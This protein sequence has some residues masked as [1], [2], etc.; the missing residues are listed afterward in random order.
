MQKPNDP[1][2][3]TK[4]SRLNDLSQDECT[5]KPLPWKHMTIL[6]WGKTWI[7]F[8]LWSHLEKY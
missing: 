3:Q 5:M 7:L 1:K 2:K 8:D 6:F 4:H